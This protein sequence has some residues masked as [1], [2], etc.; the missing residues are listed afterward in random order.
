M[1]RSN[2]RPLSPGELKGSAS[3]QRHA[4]PERDPF[5]PIRALGRPQPRL[6]SCLSTLDPP[7]DLVSH[8]RAPTFI[9]CFA[10]LCFALPT[11][12][13]AARYV[14]DLLLY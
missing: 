1:Q 13:P 10:L 14:M 5:I 2:Q 8:R 6:V 12:G 11:P 4:W 3:Q 7:P 9:L